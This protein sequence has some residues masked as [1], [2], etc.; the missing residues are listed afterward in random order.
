MKRNYIGKNILVKSL[1]LYFGVI[2]CAATAH[3]ETKKT[4]SAAQSSEA[5]SPL[6]I[7]R[8]K[9]VGSG[10]DVDV[11]IDG[12][13]VKT[14]M[15]GSR[16]KGTLSPGKHVIS[17]MPKPNTTGQREE[18]TEVTAEKGHSYSFNIAHDKAGKL[19][20]VKNP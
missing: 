10:I 1:A 20:L 19:V 3:A 6:T 5:E 8:T 4:D 14:L 12:K 11:L 7:I 13:R 9:S 15:Q 2:C 18:K 17:V 16:Y